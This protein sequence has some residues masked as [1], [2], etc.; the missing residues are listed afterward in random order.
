MNLYTKSLIVLIIF[1]F[2]LFYSKERNLAYSMQ[3]MVAPLAFHTEE[4][5]IGFSLYVIIFKQNEL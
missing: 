2:Q 5:A 1:I 4:K 3:N